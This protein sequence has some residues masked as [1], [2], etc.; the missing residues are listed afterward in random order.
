M[1]TLS[2]LLKLVNG[3][4]AL[5]MLFLLW[6]L[7]THYVFT[8]LYLYLPWLH[9]ETPL[10][11]TIFEAMILP[12]Y[13][14]YI[15]ISLPSLFAK[16]KIGLSHIAA[17]VF[18]IMVNLTTIYTWSAVQYTHF[19]ILLWVAIATCT[20]MVDVIVSTWLYFRN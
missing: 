12:L 2:L 5:M 7:N 8:G 3:A 19:P 11:I 9:Q 14:G 6:Q 13:F 20:G 17:G 1:K 16:G 10:G 18:I 15:G 4:V